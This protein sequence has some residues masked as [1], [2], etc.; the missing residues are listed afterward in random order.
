MAGAHAQRIQELRQAIRRHDYLYY[1]LAKPEISDRQYDQLL[2]ELKDLE[3]SHPE[4]VTPDSPTQRVG[5]E[6]IEG[7]QPVRHEVPM[8]SIDNTYSLE[9]L[10]EFDDRVAKALGAEKYRY[11]AEPKID[12]VAA[13]VRYENGVLVL[14]ATRGDGH[15]GDDVTSNGRTIKSIPLRL[16]EGPAGEGP[17]VPSVLEVRG[18]IYWPKDAFAAFNAKRAAAGE[19]TFA[20][21]RNGAAGTLK[22]LDPRLVA[23]R[24]LAFIAHGFGVVEPLPNDSDSQLME[25]VGR[26]GLP[27]VQHARVCESL[28]E[29]SRYI[30][31]W[32][33]TR[34]ELDYETD[35]AVIKVDSLAQ[36]ARLGQTS[37]YPRWCIA[38]K[39]AAERALTVLRE[40]SF[41]VGRLGTITPVA[42]FDPVKLAGTT[43]SN[44]TLH[45][46]DQVARLDV[47]VGDSI[48]VEKA[49]EIIPQVVQVE[50]AKRPK[51]ARPI[52]APSRCPVCKGEVGR[53]EGGV[54]V[55]CLNPECPAQLKER[56]RFYAARNQM[57]IEGLG[58]ALVE[59]LVDQ[60][61]LRHFS[62]LYALRAEKLMGMELSRHVDKKTGKTV[63]Q[64]LQQKSTENLLKAVEASKDR[65]PARLLAGLGIRHVGGRVAELLAEHFGDI[66]AIAAASEEQLSQVE[67]IGPVIAASVRQFF[68]SPQAR[69]IIKSLKAAGVRMKAE[70]AGRTAAQLPL[71]GKTIVVTGTLEHY[72]RSQIEQLIKDLGGRAAASV[73]KKTDF[74]LV[75]EEAGSKADKA[76]QLGVPTIGEQEFQNMIG[77]G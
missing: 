33:E 64:R 5:G 67:E 23:Q 75:G 4:L 45:N 77:K 10:R 14:V 6:P 51:G 11:R 24:G 31:E 15:T 70:R 50:T 28:Q 52:K 40:V 25:L 62:D 39:Y 19:E 30:D 47:R 3:A 65:G 60:G 71:A 49:G 35:G 42:H 7:F 63:I 44:A 38:Y 54:Y 26:W 74:V 76:R 73:S 68:A 8:L 1:V 20:N 55:R 57:D 29:V 66:D 13:S 16:M 9:E 27:V 61:L 32:A 59:Q 37:R 21:P 43:V 69:Q 58:P 36:R 48:F 12:G 2:Q 34:Y 56:L 17:Q 46:F 41:Q 53:D 72:S 22:Q 18:E